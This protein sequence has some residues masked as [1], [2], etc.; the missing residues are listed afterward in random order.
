MFNSHFYHRLTRKYITAFGSI[1][2]DITLVK[3]DHNNTTEIKRTKVP[4]VWGPREKY[5]IRAGEDSDL[6]RNIQ[7]TLP[8]MSFDLLGINYNPEWKTNTMHKMYRAN[9]VNTMADSVYNG[10]PY[11]LDFQLSILS[12]NK[13]DNYQILEQILPTFNPNFTFSQILIPELGFVKD[14]PVTL[15]GINNNTEYQNDWEIIVSEHVLNFSMKVFYYGPVARTKIIR[16]VFANTFLD[17]VLYAGAIVRLNV[18]DGNN[19]EYKQEDIAYQGNTLSE[20]T[21]AGVITKWDANNNYL[22][23]GGVQG[24]FTTN[25]EIKAASS[26]ATYNLASFDVSPLKVMSIEVEPDPITA[27]ANDEFG[28]NETLLEYPD[29]I[30]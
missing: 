5:L 23:L 24:L 18:N 6:E 17:P 19:G 30:E 13:D 14:V 26:N 12:R 20:S 16:R 11:D 29:T 8:L 25:T 28:F 7:Q 4:I 1:F 10:V 27:N 2:N 3:Y 22:I 9:N 15:V 21:A